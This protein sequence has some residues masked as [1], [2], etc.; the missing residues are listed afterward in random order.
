MQKATVLN[1]WGKKLW[2]SARGWAGLEL[3][4]INLMSIFLFGWESYLFCLE[5]WGGPGGEF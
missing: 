2:R 1:G 3:G 4:I 5:W